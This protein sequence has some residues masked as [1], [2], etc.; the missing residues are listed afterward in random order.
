MVQWAEKD[1][2]HAVEQAARKD[3][4]HAVNQEAAEK[5]AIRVVD[6]EGF[7]EYPGLEPILVPIQK[8]KKWDFMIGEQPAKP[9][10]VHILVI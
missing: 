8:P 3:V 5:D 7:W 6:V 10:K 2:I 9:C 4:T 1:A